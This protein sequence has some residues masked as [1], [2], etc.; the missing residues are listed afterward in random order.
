MKVFLDTN[1]YFN[2]WF[3]KSANFRYLFHFLNN[4][5]HEMIL[6]RLV[7]QEV[8]NIRRREIVAGINTAKK[9]IIALERLCGSPILEVPAESKFEK[10]DFVR[11]LKNEVDN[12]TVLEFDQIFQS[13]VV[14]RALEIRRPFRDNEKGYRDTLIWL[15]FLD[16]LA[17]EKKQTEVVFITEN[18]S[19]FFAQG[20]VICFHPDLVGDI[21]ERSIPCSIVPFGSLSS[22]IASKVDKQKHAIDYAKADSAFSEYLE[23]EG[24]RHIGALAPD[25]KRGLG[26]LIFGDFE[27]GVAFDWVSAHEIEG[28]ED[29]DVESTSDLGNGDVYVSCTFNLR[30][31]D[32]V[33]IISAREFER[34]KKSVL[35]CPNVY[36]TELVDDAVLVKVISRPYFDASFTYS[37]VRESCAG[38]AV[39]DLRFC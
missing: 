37:R 11:L 23:E 12:V 4:E 30:V 6:S 27:D 7:V 29:L 16:H 2:D 33:L 15:S 21:A 38:F 32:I 9:A 25:V 8:E 17:S 34:S 22:F 31:V 19:D 14:R 36:D 28:I 18:K 5:G 39:S 3:M 24:L 10:Y 26:Q 35:A 20:D 1:V 13:E